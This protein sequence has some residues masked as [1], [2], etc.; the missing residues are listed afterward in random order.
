MDNPSIRIKGVTII[1]H[2]GYGI[3]I[4]NSA[5]KVE[6]SDC[7]IHSPF[8]RFFD[9]PLLWVALKILHRRYLKRF[10]NRKLL[11]PDTLV[12]VHCRIKL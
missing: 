3:E 8:S 4:F 11:K 5:Q 1:N 10:P 6:L 2:E 9:D 12:K 7:F